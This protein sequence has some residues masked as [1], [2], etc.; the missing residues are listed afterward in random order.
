MKII[1]NFKSFSLAII[2]GILLIFLSVPAAGQPPALQIKI[3]KITDDS[4]PVMKAFVSVTDAQG[5]PINDLQ[6]TNF[7]VSESGKPVAGISVTP[8]ENFEQPLA[9]I[10]VMDTSGSMQGKPLADSINAAKEFNKSLASQDVLG[11]VTFAA[12]V[13]QQQ[14]LTINRSA[15]ETQLDDLKAEGATALN[16]ALIEAVG[17]LKNRSERRVVVLLTDGKQEGP[18]KFTADEVVDEA[19]R[20]ST[21]IY[22]IGFGNVDKNQLER[23]AQL[24]GGTSQINPDS[25]SVAVAFQ[26]VLSMLREQ[27]II[28]FTST[29]TADGLEHPLEMSVEYQ[30]G[31]A[32]TSRNFTA[33]P[34]QVTVDVVEPISG[35]ALGG[36]V[37]IGVEGT[38]PA[39][40]SQV[41]VY[42]DDQPLASL[43]NAPF[44]YLW[45]S[46]TVQPGSHHL[47]VIVTDQVGNTGE[48]AFDVD[49]R[50]PILVDL[51]ISDNEKIGGEATLPVQVDALADVAKI[52]YFVDEVQ[53]AE[54]TTSP[55]EFVWDT[56][57]VSPGPHTISVLAQ[58]INGYS[59]ED[60]VPVIVEMQQGTNLV[61]V[62]LI[63]LLV[64]GGVIV[65]LS[66]RS[67]RKMAAA[68]ENSVAE[69][70]IATVLTEG[71]TGSAN[72][73]ELTGINPGRIWPL[74]TGQ[75][76]LGRKRN[77]NDIPLQGLSASRSQAVIELQENGYQIRTLV[78]DNPVMVNGNLIP[79][80]TMLCHGDIIEAGESS[81]RFEGRS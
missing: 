2:A 29:L 43:Q 81:F 26:A 50:L 27:Y 79:D 14:A 49:V 31:F 35:Q 46:T 37:R 16:D 9:I 8:F 69:G 56:R 24:T 63:V 23:F 45:D 1:N 21:P 53:I 11:L 72:L 58:D 60:S 68:A 54:L 42:L 67:R 13:N 75:V 48:S 6:S 44:E 57:Q 25:T 22:T 32:S 30:N 12:D 5:F 40:I 15:M 17:M 19:V 70:G 41:D 66:M 55:F 73:V 64:A 71:E 20:W 52:V 59:A 65:P 51:V 36:K 80:A 74:S 18:S 76:K 47:K 34:G 10:L 4:F 62:A 78:S 61:W 77:E 7:K 28:E 38:A 33:T 3:E 39:P